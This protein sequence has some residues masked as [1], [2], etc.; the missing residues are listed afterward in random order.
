MRALILAAGRGE[1]MG[2][3]TTS[4]PKPL[5]RVAE[6]YLIE[7]A[8]LNVKRAG[9]RDIVINLFYHGQQIKDAL[10]DGGHYGVNISYSEETEKL[11]VGGG[12]RQAL[13]L[14]GNA[15]FIALSADVISD[16]PL[17][18]L[19]REPKGLAHLVMVDNPSFHPHGD[20]GMRDGWIDLDAQPKLNFGNIGVYRPELFA[21]SP[22]GFL[23]WRDVVFP[24]IQS[25]QV[26]G[27]YYAGLWCNVGT[28]D[29]LK[30]VN[31]SIHEDDRFNV[32]LKKIMSFRAAF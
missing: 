21:S 23:R 18:Q 5:L 22:P 8:I 27:E 7:Y 20:F 30:E 10:G 13:S 29:D 26:T 6:H 28:P 14:L 16:Y 17:I 1:R 15:P 9:I 24:A 32:L 12:I 25:K 3:L 2:S 4:T 31:D 19:P 11:E